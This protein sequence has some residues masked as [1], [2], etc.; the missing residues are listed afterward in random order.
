MIDESYSVSNPGD[1]SQVLEPIAED[2]DEL[3]MTGAPEI[4]RRRSTAKFH[5]L[6]RFTRISND[7]SDV[8]DGGAD[9]ADG[10]SIASSANFNARLMRT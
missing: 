8:K 2:D 5:Q 7:V 6:M 3:K 9:E 1:Y 10:H 4:E